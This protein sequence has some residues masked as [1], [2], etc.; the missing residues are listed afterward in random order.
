M[1][2]RTL[3]DPLWPLAQAIAIVLMGPV[4][5]VLGGA[6]ELTWT[7]AL[8]SFKLTGPLALVILG[9]QLL[10]RWSAPAGRA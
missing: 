3:T 8:A 1:N 4:I 5:L 10:L 7:A 6:G 2:M 9:G